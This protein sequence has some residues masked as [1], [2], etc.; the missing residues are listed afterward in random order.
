LPVLVAYTWISC[1]GDVIP[2]V[3]HPRFLSL[4]K[5]CTCI[6]PYSKP[7]G[8]SLYF[9]VTLTPLMHFLEAPDLPISQRREFLPGLIVH[10]DLY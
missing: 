6:E 4:K 5:R 9:I 2:T 3:T 1:F 7:N 10:L 8:V